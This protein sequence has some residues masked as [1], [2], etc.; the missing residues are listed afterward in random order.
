MIDRLLI[1]SEIFQ[2]K[3]KY[4]ACDLKC[5]Y[6]VFTL[7]ELLLL[8]A[9]APENKPTVGFTI[10]TQ[11][12]L[13]NDFADMSPLTVTVKATNTGSGQLCCSFSK[14]SIKSHHIIP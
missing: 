14:L 13:E 11:S 1:T 3:G 9:V 4:Y 10:D 6:C 2:G 12:E 8:F 5:R 7:C